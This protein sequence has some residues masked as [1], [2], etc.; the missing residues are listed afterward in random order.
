MGE[1]KIWDVIVGQVWDCFPGFCEMPRDMVEVSPTPSLHTLACRSGWQ[2]ASVD[3]L[4]GIG[5]TILVTLDKLAIQ[6]TSSPPSFIPSLIT[7]GQLYQ[8]TLELYYRE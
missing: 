1:A 2:E 8:P 5:Y 4:V 7:I 6:P 3:Q